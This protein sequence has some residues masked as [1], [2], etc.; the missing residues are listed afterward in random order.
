VQKASHRPFDATVTAVM[1]K[2]WTVSEEREKA[3]YFRERRSM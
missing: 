1:M 2:R 3:G